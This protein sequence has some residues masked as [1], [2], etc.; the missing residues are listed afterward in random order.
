MTTIED[1]MALT[2]LIGYFEGRFP[3]GEEYD[4]QRSNRT[5]RS[6]A[7]ASNGEPYVVVADHQWHPTREAVIEAA[8]RTFDAYASGKKGKLY[9]RVR[10]E[11]DQQKQGWRFYMRLLISD[12]P[13]KKE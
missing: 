1:A 9:W 13:E 7:T 6:G 2:A 8:M 4:P 3:V 10:P 12:K 11:I 5:V